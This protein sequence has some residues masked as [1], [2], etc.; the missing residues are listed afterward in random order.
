MYSYAVRRQIKDAVIQARVKRFSRVE[1]IA[2]VKS[3]TKVDISMRYL[4][5]MIKLLK[6]NAPKEL[7]ILKTSRYAFI[8]EI[9]KSKQEIEEYIKEAWR[10]FHTSEGDKYLQLNCLKELHQLTISR[11]NIIDVLP[12]Y[13]GVEAEERG[14]HKE[15]IS[16]HILETSQENTRR[17]QAIF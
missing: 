7:E 17:S 15:T 1:T 12:H 14:R 5:T 9:F 13:A 3:L 10:I 16:T 11:S 2:Y 6:M 8:D 4:D